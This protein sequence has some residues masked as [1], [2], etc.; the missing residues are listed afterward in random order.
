MRLHKIIEN[1]EGFP[2]SYLKEVKDMGGKFLNHLVALKRDYSL[3][4]ASLGRIQNSNTHFVQPNRLE[5][6]S[7]NFHL[8]SLLGQ[9]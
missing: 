1:Q 6:L 4:Y 9:F 8:T 3:E 7:R 2:V 5:V